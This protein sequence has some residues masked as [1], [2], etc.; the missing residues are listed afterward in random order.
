[1]ISADVQAPTLRL[2]R[3][4]DGRLGQREVRQGPADGDQAR[5]STQPARRTRS[6]EQQHDGEC[7][8]RNADCAAQVQRH[9]D[10]TDSLGG[11]A[12]PKFVQKLAIS[13]VSG[14]TLSACSC[15][16]GVSTIAEPLPPRNKQMQP[17]QS[18]L[19]RPAAR[20]PSASPP[21]LAAAELANSVEGFG[22]T[23]AAMEL[24]R[25][26][27]RS[28]ADRRAARSGDR[29]GDLEVS[30]RRL[31]FARTR[32]NAYGRRAQRRGA[33]GVAQEHR[34]RAASDL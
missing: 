22:W 23:L 6:D 29:V 16:S 26:H 15:N 13:T 1:M 31:K 3:L 33:E 9:R 27:P 30:S 4:G 12:R 2:E 32:R 5:D 8:I 11:S 19:T 20:R 25:S 21:A 14:S 34:S 28:S 24:P 17:S 10:H 18:L 7:Q